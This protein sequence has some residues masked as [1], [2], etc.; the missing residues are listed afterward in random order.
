MNLV[1]NIHFISNG[2]RQSKNYFSVKINIYHFV[3]GLT[4]VSKDLLYF[5]NYFLQYVPE[6]PGVA[7][8]I[9]NVYIN[10][11]S[12]LLQLPFSKSTV[13]AR[14]FST[15]N[16]QANT[17]H[18]EIM[19]DLEYSNLYANVFMS[20]AMPIRLAGSINRSLIC[21]EQSNFC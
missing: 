10:N 13:S 17:S 12:T 3:R 9:I 8:S 5:L 7:N 16:K 18:S 21:A 6:N 4:E 15:H 20:Q 11:K 2:R 14:P 1:V 19:R